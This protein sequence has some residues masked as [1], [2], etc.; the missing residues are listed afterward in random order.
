MRK[1]GGRGRGWLQKRPDVRRRG[2][3]VS[4]SLLVDVFSVCET[5]IRDRLTAVCDVAHGY[6]CQRL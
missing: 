5:S 2:A 3:V 6:D 4:G 1:R